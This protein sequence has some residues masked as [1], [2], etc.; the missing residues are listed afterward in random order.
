MVTI[1]LKDFRSRRLEEASIAV[2]TP[3]A[4][5]EQVLDE[6]PELVSLAVGRIANRW[7]NPP[8][9]PSD[10]V[11]IVAVHPTMAEAMRRAGALLR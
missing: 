10:V 3:G 11:D 6:A 7:T 2:L 5:V 1:N 8:R 4:L 9:S